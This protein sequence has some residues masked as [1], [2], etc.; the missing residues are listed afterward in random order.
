M[1]QEQDFLVF[2]VLAV[3]S[4]ETSDTVVQLEGRNNN[5]DCP[6]LEG[7]DKE[8]YWE[9]EWQVQGVEMT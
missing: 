4:M 3:G 2:G 8:G 9:L 1:L 5:V 7:K 6:R